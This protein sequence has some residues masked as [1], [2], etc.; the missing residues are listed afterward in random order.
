M[1]SDEAT[2]S[3][4][5]TR[6]RRCRATCPGLSESARD[7]DGISG[8]R[9]GG[10]AINCVNGNGRWTGTPKRWGCSSFPGSA[11]WGFLLIL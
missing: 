6:G 9:P 4:R 2:R 5:Q 3:E 7:V 1:L 11:R 8:S 10:T